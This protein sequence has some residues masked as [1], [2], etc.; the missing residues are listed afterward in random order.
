M[1][2]T[3]GQAACLR[4]PCVLAC[5]M[6]SLAIVIT[7]V[8]SLS[9]SLFLSFLSSVFTT[10]WATHSPWSILKCDRW[11]YT[12][13]VLLLLVIN[14]LPRCTVTKIFVVR[15]LGQSQNKK[16]VWKSF[17][18]STCLKHCLNIGPG[19]FNH[20]CPTS[21]GDCKRSWQL[22]TLT[23]LFLSRRLPW[24]RC[25][26]LF[27]L[28]S[29][30][31]LDQAPPEVVFAMCSW[32]LLLPT[33]SLSLSLLRVLLL[34]HFEET[35]K[36]EISPPPHILAQR[37]RRWVT[38]ICPDG[39]DRIV[40]CWGPYQGILATTRTNKTNHKIDAIDNNRFAGK[41]DI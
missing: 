38:P 15:L 25:C 11:S 31:L 41:N 16:F 36:A 33:V 29:F 17:L 8:Q 4:A 23:F 14:I 26:P 20:S 40:A 34:I 32:P 28:I 2:I 30:F 3:F 9:L 10:A 12:S 27:S 22:L 5:A 13:L 7:I 1:S 37:R 6:R 39:R 24:M 18:N 35:P 21:G 19:G